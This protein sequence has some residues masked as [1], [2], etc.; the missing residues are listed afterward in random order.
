MARRTLADMDAE[1]LIRLANRTD[2]TPDMR[3]QFLHDAY[4]W[5][6]KTF[7]HPELQAVL[8]DILRA[9]SD[10]FG[11]A[12]PNIWF[13]DF[14]FDVTHSRPLEPRDLQYIERQT[15]TVGNPSIYHWWGNQFYVDRKP[16]ADTTIRVFYI[17]VPD[18]IADTA[19][20]QIS[21]AYDVIIISKAAELGLAS[22]RDFADAAAQ[23]Q[24]LNAHAV[25]MKLPVR[26]DA[27]NSEGLG[28]QVRLK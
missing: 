8:T 11:N 23:K 1:L 6:C 16:L 28:V 3:H 12:L 7:I 15:K 13:P 26:E 25:E 5:T 10:T 19:P 14:V 20:V 17:R 18:E 22:V 9:N 21:R 27:K 4:I 2:L 24:L